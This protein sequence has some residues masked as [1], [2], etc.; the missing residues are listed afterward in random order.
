MKRL[1]LTLAGVL[2]VSR[3]SSVQ[4]T[5]LLNEIHLRTPPSTDLTPADGNFEFIELKSDTGDVEACTDL[6][7]LVIENDG[8]GVGE[9]KQAWKLQHE[10]GTWMST[11][12]NGLLLLGDDYIRPDSPYQFIKAPQTTMGDPDGMGTDDLEDANALTILLVR[13]TTIP[14]PDPLT[15][16]VDADVDVGDIG[17]GIFDWARTPRPPGSLAAAPWSQIVDSIGFNGDQGNVIKIAYSGTAA[18][19]SRSNTVKGV[20]QSNGTSNFMPH[21]MAR[22]ATSNVP[23]SRLAWYGGTVAGTTGDAVTYGAS[24]FNLLGA[25]WKGLVTPGQPNLSTAPV[26]P[27]FLINE[28]NLNPPG[29]PGR[30]PDPAF[31]PVAVANDGNFEYVEIINTTANQIGGTNFSGSLANYTLLVVDSGGSSMGRIREAWSLTK[32]ATG[33]TGLLVLGDDYQEGSSPFA[34]LFDPAT[35]LADPSEVV[36]TTAPPKLSASNLGMGDLA[37]NGATL[38]LVQHFSGHVDDDIDTNN[39]GVRD[40]SPWGT[41]V[42]SVSV[43]EIDAVNALVPLHGGYSLAK[44]DIVVAGKHYNADN[45]SRILGNVTPNVTTAWSAGVLGSNSPFALS[46]RNG[47]SITGSGTA[48]LGAASPGRANYSGTSLPAAGTFRIN[49][50]NINPPTSPDNTEYVEVIS[51][52]PNA[53]M[54]NLWLIVLDAT[55]GGSGTVK[56][57]IDLRGQSTGGNRLALFGD[58]VEEDTSVLVQFA[59]GRTLRDDPASFNANGTENAAGG[60]NFTPDSIAPDNGVSV[61]LVSYTAPTPTGVPATPD[62]DLDA[63]NDGTLDVAPPWTLVDGISTGNGVGAVPV[64]PAPGF[65]PG[66]VSRYAGN[67]TANSAGAW[68]GGELTGGTATSFDYSNN[69]FGSFKGA[70]SPGRQNVTATPNNA[71][72]LL[73]NEINI[74]PPGGDNNKEF[75]ELRSTDNSALSAIGYSVLLI[76][77]DGAD[78]GKVLRVWDL[79]SAATGSNGL[80][81]MGVGYDTSVPWTGAAAPETATK[82]FA[83]ETMVL[84]D[85]GFTTDNGAV[86][87]L[88]VKNFKGRV[89]DDLDEGTQADLTAAD[90]HVFTTP[91]PW[92][93]LADSVAMKGFVVPEIGPPVLE[94]FIFPGTADLTVPIPPIPANGYTPDTVARFAGNSA[95]NNSAAW[96]GA[97]LF[98]TAGTSTVYDPVQYFPSTLNGGKVTPGQANI[99]ALTD[100]SDPDHDGVLHIM[101]TALGMD[102]F[103]ADNYKLPQPSMVTLNNVLQPAF[104]VVLP[105]GGVSGITYTV[106]AAFNLENPSDWTDFTV[107]SSTVADSPG[108]G[109]ETRTYVLHPLLVPQL[110]TYKRAF[111]RLK[112]QRP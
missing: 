66:N 61:L 23:N 90:D 1:L 22:S 88:L 103:V 6:W 84:D 59:S 17:N 54:R 36:S 107:L 18:N 80:L 60:F 94:G 4:A 44:P 27:V 102:T 95:A 13:R 47:F 33:T 32:F 50:I 79:D 82:L 5:I 78:T 70:A 77:N 21:T 51:S 98:G 101:E 83:P 71:V 37:N 45:L 104:V 65:S 106:Q 56:K 40:L 42:D 74:N 89:G 28:I 100:N 48:F 72:G 30:S 111:F 9:V 41:L 91:L 76:D 99:T 52:A 87:V 75:V 97:N 69:F 19:L 46:H 25:T 112:V 86:T 15:G 57:V 85:I 81:L 108:S 53:L 26:P 58:G 62:A 7:I 38:F 93:T 73:L 16:A 55:P 8:G 96:Y 11:G 29:T 12:K 110:Q 68:F 34:N 35:Q 109:F 2:L 20:P 67:M 10:D 92:A 24:Y 105:S 39:D 63:G 3:A 49:E 31:P 14:T 64:L 43:P